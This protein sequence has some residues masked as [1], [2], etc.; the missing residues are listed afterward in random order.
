MAAAPSKLAASQTTAKAGDPLTKLIQHAD[1]L[2]RLADEIDEAALEAQ[3]LIEE[4]KK[5]GRRFEQ[6]Q[7]LLNETTE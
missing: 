1:Y 7:K 3:Q 2:R 6:L 5:N 4:A